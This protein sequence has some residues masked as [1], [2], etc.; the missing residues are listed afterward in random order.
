MRFEVIN[1]DGKV[2]FHTEYKECMPSVDDIKHLE[3]NGY[4]FK[5]G[6]KIVKANKIDISAMGTETK[7]VPKGRSK[8]R[9]LF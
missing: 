3:A 2:V 9:Q 1:R 4:K 5:I 6:G 7:D 8:R